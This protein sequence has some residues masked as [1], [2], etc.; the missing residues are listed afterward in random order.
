MCEFCLDK[1]G[2]KFFKKYLLVIFLIAVIF[3]SS[4]CDAPKNNPF[5]PSNPNYS[6]VTIKGVV[7]TFSL[8]YTGIAGVS[9][10]WSQS[11]TL[12]NT[13]NNGNF[14]IGNILPVN[15][16]LIFQKDG[17]R[18]D[19]MDVIW[20]SSKLLNY[21]VNLNR[22]PLLD[23][24]SIYSVVINLFTPPGQSY[25][26]TVAAR[27]LDKDNDIDTVYV[28]NSQLN[29]KKAL[30]FDV[31]NKLYEAVLTTQDLN[32]ADIEQTIG[33]DFNI[34]VKDIFNREYN[35][36]SSKVT[37]VIKNGVSIQFPANDTTVTSTP[38]FTWQR[39][40]TGY[41]FSYMIEIYTNDFANSQLVFSGENISSDSVSYQLT[42][43]LSA[44]SYYWVIWVTDQ[45]QNRCRS[46]PAT[47][48]VK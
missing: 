19:T 21:Q 2:I 36:G 40:K 1:L 34:V 13:D 43:P 35:V 17:Y 10:Y 6:F 12:V 38:L 22:I 30:G 33:L 20:G 8:P 46:L 11:N 9:V 37:R 44:R 32:I 29:L 42:T 47:F 23:S 4:S 5:D 15:G 7:Q 28:E 3:L 25:Q 41:P 27:I 18:S 45:F 14:T 26:L 16:K 48:N 24:I 31:T 39:Y